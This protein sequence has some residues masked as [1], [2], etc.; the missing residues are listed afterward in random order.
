MTFEEI[1]KLYIM[2]I[3]TFG[4]CDLDEQKFIGCAYTLNEIDLSEAMNAIL[5]AIDA[6]TLKPDFAPSPIK[7]RAIVMQSRK[8]K[9]QIE[10]YSTESQIGKLSLQLAKKIYPDI[11]DRE[12]FDSIEELEKAKRIR[13]MMQDKE[14]RRIFDEKKSLLEKRIVKGETLENAMKAIL[15][16]YSQNEIEFLTFS[17]LI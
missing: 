7:I 3:S 15:S 14:F 17:L 6:E 5:E 11:A 10:D 1:K 9:L 16:C 2:L 8:K 12:Q 13:K 4:R